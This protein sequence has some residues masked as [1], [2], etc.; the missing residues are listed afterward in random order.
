[1]DAILWA[2]LSRQRTRK[3]GPV[4]NGTGN[5]YVQGEC[6]GTGYTITWDNESAI[7]FTATFQLTDTQTPGTY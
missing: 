3:Y 2:S 7:K 1:V 5:K 4:G 6:I